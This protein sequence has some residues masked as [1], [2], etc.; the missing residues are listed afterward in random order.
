MA[1]CILAALMLAAPSASRAQP[2]E[3]PPA[4]ATQEGP[5]PAPPRHRGGDYAY[6]E[7]VQR[8]AQ[9]LAERHGWSAEATLG[10]L[11]Q[12]RYLPRVAQLIMPPAA[13]TAKN[14]AAYRSRFIEPK[15]LQAGVQF[16]NTHDWLLRKAERTYGVPA[17][18]VVGIIGVETYY[19]R[20]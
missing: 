4:A 17:S 10:T 18:L 8:F 7:E 1:G 11:S 13:G 14:W 2:P 16:W 3:A 9:E 5:A 20:H 12:A 6:R 15:R 19:G